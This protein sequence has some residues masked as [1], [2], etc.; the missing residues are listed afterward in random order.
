MVYDGDGLYSVKLEVPDPE[1]SDVALELLV[2]VSPV[3]GVPLEL[4]RVDGRI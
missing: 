4:L 3:D 1:L 2:A